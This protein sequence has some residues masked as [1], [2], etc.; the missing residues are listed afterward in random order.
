LE[1]KLVIHGSSDFGKGESS[2]VS[3]T[4][5]EYELSVAASAFTKHNATAIIQIQ[6]DVFMNRHRSDVLRYVCKFMVK[7][8]FKLALHVMNW[9]D[10]HVFNEAISPS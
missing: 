7:F 5:K 10:S 4:V 2:N 1:I 8:R 3:G 6:S 9:L